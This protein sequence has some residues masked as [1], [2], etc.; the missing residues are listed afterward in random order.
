MKKSRLTAALLAFGISASMIFQTP[1]YAAEDTAVTAAAASTITTNSISGWPQG[2]DITSAAAVVM[3]DTTN[4]ILYAKDMDQSLSPA[5]AVKIMT[6]LLALENSQLTDQVTMTE[7]GVSGVTDG[8]AHISSQLGEVFTMEQCLYAI[9]LASA[10]DIA[11]QIAEQIGGS[12]EA[13]VEK[14]NSRAQ[15]LGCTNTVFTNPTGL[16]DDNQHTTA[17]DLALIMQAAINT[18]GFRDIA[19]ATSYTIPATNVSGGARNLTSSFSL[20]NQT[21]SAYYSGCIGG[22]ESTTTASGSV[23]VTAAERNSTTL[24]CVVMNGDTGQTANEATTL[25]DYGFGN[26]QLLDLGQED[27]HIL[28]GGQVMIP[29][30]ATSDDLTTEDTESDGQ[31]SRTYSFGGTQVGTAVIENTVEDSA[32]AD[33][34]ENDTNMEAARVSQNASPVPYFIIGGVGVLLLV[35]LLL[36][37]IK[38][39][40][41]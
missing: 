23:L 13:F 17:H 28:S 40:K 2:P 29:S 8:G 25:M 15:E 36:R 20:T 1:V 41:S 32:T 5:G 18:D 34:Q 38:V 39:I 7:T 37:M 19:S 11:L 9:M 12:V 22:R 16:P 33:S 14:M 24:I 35:L 10:N 26:F 3:E 30:G 6:C 4:T 31:I 21:A 27:F